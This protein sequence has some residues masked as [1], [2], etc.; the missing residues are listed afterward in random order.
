MCVYIYIESL[1][2]VADMSIGVQYSRMC[3][4]PRIV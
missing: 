3:A 4:D 1:F 2:I